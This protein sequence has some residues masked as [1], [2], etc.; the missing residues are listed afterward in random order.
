MRMKK[1]EME[2]RK[3]K[4]LEWDQT[5]RE[6]PNKVL[7][8]KW[9]QSRRRHMK[10][11]LFR[12][13][14]KWWKLNLNWRKQ[15]LWPVAPLTQAFSFRGCVPLLVWHTCLICALLLV[16]TISRQSLCGGNIGL[17]SSNSSY[18]QRAPFWSDIASQ[19]SRKIPAWSGLNQG[20]Y[21]QV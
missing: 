14:C 19:N 11:T 4:W 17:L 18:S 20:L 9:K 15:S 7:F 5:G 3:D 12:T 8:L 10:S 16:G 2:T 13:Q 21:P 6:P 1:Q